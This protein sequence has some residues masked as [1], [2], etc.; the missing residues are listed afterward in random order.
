MIRHPDRVSLYPVRVSALYI[1]LTKIIYPN[2][3][4]TFMMG[5]I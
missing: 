3:R 2:G 5:Y 1:I 4:G